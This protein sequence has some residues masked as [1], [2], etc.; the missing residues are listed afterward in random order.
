MEN[1]KKLIDEL[2][3]ASKLY[4]NGGESPL[5]DREYDAKLRTLRELEKTTGIVYSNSPTINVGAKVLPN[6]NRVK[7]PYRP[8]LSLPDVHSADEIIKLSDGYDMIASVKCDGLSVRL[9][10]NNGELISANTRGDGEYGQDISEHVK[11]FLNIPLHIEKDGEYI[12][13]GEAVIYN[14][15]FEIVN[16]NNEFKND[17]NT[18]SGSLALLDMSIVKNRR[19]SFVAWDVIKGGKA[20]EFHHNIEEAEGLGFTTAPMLALDCTKIEKI[21]IDEINNLLLQIAKEKGIPCDGVVWKIND[22]AAGDAKGRT[23]KFFRNAVAWKPVDEEY[24]TELIDIELSLG[25]TGQLTPVAIYKPIMIDGSECSRASLHNLSVMNETIG[26]NPYV[27]EKIFVYKAQKIIPQISWA[28]KENKENKSLIKINSVCPVCGASIEVEDNNGIITLWCG[29]PECEGQLLNRI[30]HY[31]SKKGLDIKGL[32]KATIEKL[33]DWGWVNGIKDI[34]DLE[35]YRSEWE[36]KPGFGKA[37]VGKILD[38]IN[39]EGRHTKLEAF[40]SA[41]GMPL[42]GRAVAKQII[43]YYSTWNEFREAVGGDWTEFDGFGP[44]MSKAI[45]NFDYTE[46]DE[47]AGMLDFEQTEV[48]NDV[49]PAAAIKDKTF[50]VT[51]KLQNYTRDSIKAEIESLGGKVTGSVTSK[52]D[53]LLTNTPDSGTAKNR[54]A[55]RLGIKII[56]ENDYLKMKG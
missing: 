4:Y 42:I 8:M 22:I 20:K 39:A 56:T 15:D 55:Q 29:N 23:E 11:H 54:D 37:S 3:N 36:S 24:E 1:I 27:G 50:C 46:A 16:K 7:I 26:L 6:L 41:L 33:I 17:R 18:A 5:S 47:I 48:Q 31:A 45:N 19:L 14:Q 49:T 25:R 9:I 35:K 38:A 2:N 13:D 28:E 21:E 34:Y 40:I 52:T 32:S 44:E 30:D 10:Y 51:G 43:K 53:Y 12:I